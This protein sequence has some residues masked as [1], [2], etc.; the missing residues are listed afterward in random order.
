MAT[1]GYTSTPTDNW[2]NHSANYVN[3]CKF[4]LAENGVV[5]S[6][7]MYL[8]NQ[9][10]GHASCYVKGVIYSDSGGVPATLQVEGSAV[11]VLDNAA[12]A[13]V[14]SAA[15]KVLSAGTYWLGVFGDDA[16]VGIDRGYVSSGGNTA[17]SSDTYSNGA[18]ATYIVGETRTYILGIYATYTTG[19]LLTTNASAV[20]LAVSSAVLSNSR[21]TW[22]GL[23]V[24]R[25][26]QG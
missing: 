5:S 24:T 6:I 3:L 17:Y 26:L 4:T 11:Q 23:T 15:P 19:T 25:L 9:Q 8:G 22:A 7:S 14:V 1:F 13:W 21:T 12:Y 10:T 16:A 18:A 20:G 2:V